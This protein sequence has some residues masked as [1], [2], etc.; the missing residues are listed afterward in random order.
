MR[1]ASV[2]V[3]LDEV[4][5][6][7]A[8]HGLPLAAPL[9]LVYERAIP[10]AL[11]FARTLDISL[12]FFAVGRDLERHENAAILRDAAA[13]GHEV[14][15]HSLSHYY[16]LTRRPRSEL[17]REVTLGADAIERAVGERPRGF[18]A[19]GYTMSDELF[20]VLAGA[21]VRY[22]SS[23]FPSPPYYAAKSAA[24][25]ASRLRGRKSS[26]IVAAPHV[27][28]APT[29]PY[30]VGRPF[31]SVGSGLRELPIQVTPKV[32][33]PYIGTSLV[34]LGPDGARLFTRT[35]LG[36]PFV[37]LELHGFDF[38][39]LDDGLGALAAHQPDAQLSRD[40]KLASLG[41]ALELLKR[42]EFSFVRLDTAADA[43]LA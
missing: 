9:H 3:D 13:R 43:L 17:E 4:R 14:G 12:T 28:R 8:L 11:D 39:G 34:M 18:R 31:S 30:R 20:D 1:L 15:N 42:H 5:H 10:R 19:P 26:A 16:D 6:Y 32:R 25:L 29:R 40:R 27:L 22:D 35:L 41:A 36:E 21:G 37:N 2:S 33:L 24:M 23:V 7:F 38:L